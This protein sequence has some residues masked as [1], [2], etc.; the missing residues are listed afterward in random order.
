MLK[1]LGQVVLRYRVTTAETNN[2]RRANQT[3]PRAR[4]LDVLSR[5]ISHVM[6]SKM[7]S[8]EGGKWD[9]YFFLLL[10]RN[11]RLWGQARARLFGFRERVNLYK[12]IN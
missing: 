8:K 11:L 1:K 12:A 6:L 7:Y 2:T 5:N 9:E 3:P 10:N 4:V